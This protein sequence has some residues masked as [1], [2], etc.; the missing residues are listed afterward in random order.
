ME[1]FMPCRLIRDDML[2]S[3]R[4]LALPV[5]ARWLYVTILLSADD[6]GLFEATAFK[7]AR[8]SDIKRETGER[9]LTML[10]DSDLVRL[11]E[12]N[13]KRYG[14][15]PRFRQRIQIKNLKH[16]APP[17]A[18]MCDDADAL[19]KI[20]HLVFKTTVGKPLDNSCATVGQ[21]PE[22]KAKAKLEAKEQQKEET[23]KTKQRA[24]R[25]QAVTC[26]A[27]V[28]Q[29]VWAD[30]L[31]LRKVKKAPV[32]ES[33]L[34]GIEREAKAAGISLQ[35]AMAY[36]CARGW[37][38]FRSEWMQSAAQ[39]QYAKQPTRRSIH[40]ERADTIRALTGRDRQS[41]GEIIDIGPDPASVD[42]A[43]F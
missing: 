35:D 2:E 1:A 7:L 36:S 14:F 9:L 12:V 22:A 8:R 11:Y 34:A 28:D 38:G 24:T 5:E 26:P 20:K 16:P 32:T 42:W 6:L 21:P 17:D 27:G 19:N 4:V 10:A 13:G 29:Q 39:T 40:D 3:E 33:A 18:L 31:Q 23:E 15:I 25:S 30:W 43:P 41:A 37:A